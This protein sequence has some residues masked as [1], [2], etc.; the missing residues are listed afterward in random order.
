ML[1]ATCASSSVMKPRARLT[2]TNRPSSEAPSTISGAA[3]FRN[4]VCSTSV[5]PR[6]LGGRYRTRASASSVP[7]IVAS[8][9]LARPSRIDSQNAWV[10]PGTPLHSRYHCVVNPFQVKLTCGSPVVTLLKL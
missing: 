9:V 8:T 5:L 6:N 4:M 3:M 10:S 7:T 1:N 2:V